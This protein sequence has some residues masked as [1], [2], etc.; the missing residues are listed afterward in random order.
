MNDVIHEYTDA[1]TQRHRDTETQRHKDTKTQKHRDIEKHSE[2]TGQF[3][4]AVSIW[5]FPC[6]GMLL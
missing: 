2:E 1:H 3:Q 5:Q 4:T 6:P